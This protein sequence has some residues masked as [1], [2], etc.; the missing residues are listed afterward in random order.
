M[1]TSRTTWAVTAFIEAARIVAAA[2][3]NAK[4]PQSVAVP[5]RDRGPA[6]T[7]R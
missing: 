4:P 2:N 1:K 3:D 5:P 6:G 7:P